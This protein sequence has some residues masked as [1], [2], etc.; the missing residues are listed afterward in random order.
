MN[1]LYL[2]A[3]GSICTSALG[4]ILLLL[5]N[6]FDNQSFISLMEN[7]GL[8]NK[9]NHTP[10]IY[11]SI[12]KVYG[13]DLLIKCPMGI[14]FKDLLKNED[15]IKT[16][17][18]ARMIQV[19]YLQKFIL[20]R[21]IDNIKCGYEF[22]PIN[23]KKNEIMLGFKINHKPMLINT[24]ENPHVLISG[25]TGCGKSY[26]QYYILMNLINNL[27]EK[28]LSLYLL[29]FS[30]NDYS[31]LGFSKVKQCRS[32]ENT[33]NGIQIVLQKILNIKKYRETLL[34]E[35]EV[36]SIKE[37]NKIKGVTKQHK[38]YIFCEEFSFLEDV[39]SKDN[40]ET[41]EY[42]QTSI[43][44]IIRT[45]RAFDIHV[46]MCLQRSTADNINTTVKSQCLKISGYQ[47]SELNSRIAVDSDICTLLS[48]ENHEFACCTNKDYEIFTPPV[49]N[50]NIIK[51]FTNQFKEEPIIDVKIK[52]TK[53]TCRKEMRYLTKEEVE[54]FKRKSKQKPIKADKVLDSTLIKFKENKF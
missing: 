12:N 53:Q 41:Q 15:K 20:L 17:Y 24:D 3:Y 40:K 18:S 39:V 11:K 23:H 2:C 36:T 29:Q 54:E 51:N 37:Y 1:F 26:L 19:E 33:L 22:K 48:K 52:E 16:Y 21:I 28:Q 9:L 13:K 4:Y 8:K 31:I 50:D 43:S 35:Y 6:K 32:Y 46:V 38:I 34:E 30:K 42:I 47:N 45:G 5:L 44:D 25:F 49:L 10:I 14:G 27:S 7:C